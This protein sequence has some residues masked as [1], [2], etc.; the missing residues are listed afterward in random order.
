M[1]ETVCGQ[2][3]DG[4]FGAGEVVEIRAY[5]CQGKGPWEGWAKGAGI[6]FG[7]FDNASDFHAAAVLLDKA[8]ARGIYFTLNP[9]VP[10][11]LGRAVNRL[12]AAEIKSQTTADKSIRCIRWLPFDFDPIRAGA[13]SDLNSSGPELAQAEEMQDAVAAWLKQEMGIPIGHRAMSGNG[14]HLLVRVP[15]LPPGDETTTLVRNC[16]HAVARR[17]SGPTVD[18]D[19][20]VFNPARIWKLYGT[21]ARKSDHTEARPQ[22]RALL[23]WARP[24]AEIP[25][26]DMDA[27]RRLAAMGAE[28][29]S[30]TVT[31]PTGGRGERAAQSGGE[32]SGGLGALDLPAYLGHY[33][34]GFVEKTKGDLNLYVLRQ[35]VFNPEHAGRDAAI[36]QGRDGKITYQCFHNSC[37]GKTWR[38]ARELI[39]GAE[40][41]ARFCAGYRPDWTP[42]PERERV[43][44]RTRGKNSAAREPAP[45]RP[46]VYQSNGNWRLDP[47]A[48]SD[49]FQET[50]RPMVGVGEG[51]ACGF[52]RYNPKSGCW[53]SIDAQWIRRRVSE[54]MGDLRNPSWVDKVVAQIHT[55][56]WVDADRIRPRGLFLCVKNG[57]WDI[58]ARELREH[59]PRYMARFQLPVRFDP[60]AKCPLWEKTLD[61]IFADDP[62]KKDVLRTFMGYCLYPRILFP[63]V[64]FAIGGGANGKGVVE[65]VLCAMLGDRAV[66]HLSLARLEDRFGVVELKDK[67]L[68][69]CGETETGLVDVSKFKQVSAGD[70]VQAEVKY[71]GD[72]KFVPI[73]KHFISMNYFPRVAEKTRS[74]YRRIHVLEFKRTFESGEADPSLKWKLEE[75]LD[76]IFFWALEGLDYVLGEMCL[77]ESEACKDAGLR[78]QVANNPLMLW[79]EEECLVGPVHWTKSA[80]AYGAYRQWADSGGLR[81]IS[82]ERFLEFLRLH[83][84]VSYRRTSQDRLID[85]LGLRPAG[86]QASP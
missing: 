36:C 86:D 64:L 17:F 46:Y 66:S 54:D 32:S 21:T 56:L 53:D 13:A 82:R 10:D 19:L 77:Y 55:D 78:M 38:D 39:S 7:Y 22:R 29:A 31:G 70:E 41:V 20:K 61:E 1:T 67:L 5:G 23:D 79:V 51:R 50:F 3:Y 83:Y 12:K 69:S 44:T 59:G 35:C 65:H 30:P 72:C 16:L 58:E 45:P 33:G 84:G 57:M 37:A 81:P 73:A 40:S 9:V 63:G 71:A 60:D 62:S 85:G 43:R 2:V 52:L 11:L 27:V 74:F 6:V 42:T 8:G 28:E 76:G 24:L 25:V 75:E 48:A 68:N 15:D 47:A 49:Y 4:F 14:A 18:V 34:V 80:E 26:A